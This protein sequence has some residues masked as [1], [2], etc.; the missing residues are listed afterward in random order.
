LTALRV[1]SISSQVA[2]GPVGNSA[3]VPAL[4]SLGLTVHQIPTVILSNHPGLGEPAGF[5]T[6]ARNIGGILGALENLGVLQKCSAVLTGYFAASDQVFS[7][8]RAIRRMKEANRELFYLCDPVL[9]DD[10][11]GLYVALKVAEAIRDELM[12]LADCIAP[13]RFELEWLSERLV[14]S[15]ASA[16]R[17][18]AALPCHE[19]LA[20]SIPGAKGEIAT[21]VIHGEEWT[22]RTTPLI[23]HVPHGTG[24]LLSGL[25]LG[26]RI[27]GAGP[28]EALAA[29]STTLQQVIAASHGSP[30]LN[31]AE[32]LR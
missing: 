29:A 12:P 21:L 16:R 23:N 2:Y 11:K 22:E 26:H 9:G 24:D 1:L 13:N 10:P 20:T 14:T 18:A 17:A 4:E 7:V 8:A 32:G 30:A 28:G 25:Y 5:R 3:A 27:R 15:P 31:L 6:E 19:V